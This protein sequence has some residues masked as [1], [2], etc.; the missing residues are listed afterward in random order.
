MS[1]NGERFYAAKATQFKREASHTGFKNS[2]LTA[3]NNVLQR[4][5]IELN[6]TSAP[7]RM[8][9]TETA[10]DLDADLE[11]VLHSGMDYHLTLLKGGKLQDT[12]LT[13]LMREYDRVVALALVHRQQDAAAAATDGA[14]MGEFDD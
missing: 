6:M 4:L 14:T 12:G 7:D 3:G 2:Y 8:V 1:I 5:Y 11:F 9:D 13:E 10:I